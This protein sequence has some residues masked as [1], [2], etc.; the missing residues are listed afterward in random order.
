MNAGLSLDEFYSATDTLIGA[1][2]SL[3]ASSKIAASFSTLLQATHARTE[4]R[5]KVLAATA[6]PKYIAL[7][8]GI[9]DDAL[10][11]HLDLCEDDNASVRH[12]AIK[13]LPAFAVSVPGFTSKV[14]DV[15]CQ[16]LQTDNTEEAAV[17]SASLTSCFYSDPAASST[18]IFHQIS[19]N[20][21]PS[22]RRKS[23]AFLQHNFSASLSPSAALAYI[24]GLNQFLHAASAVV[25][26]GQSPWI[27]E[28]GLSEMMA[29]ICAIVTSADSWYSTDP[30]I[31]LTA[32]EMVSS[33][34]ES[35]AL[36]DPAS[37]SSIKTLTTAVHQIST[38]CLK[39]PALNSSA[40]MDFLFA[41]VFAGKQLRKFSSDTNRLYALRICADAAKFW[42]PP[43][44]LANNSG[45]VL[46][47]SFKVLSAGIEDL[48]KRHIPSSEDGNLSTLMYSKLE[49]ILVILY[50]VDSKSP[51]ELQKYTAHKQ[52]DLLLHLRAIYKSA[53][54]AI[55]S[56]APTSAV[57][58]T[59]PKLQKQRK[60]LENVLTVVK[61]LL[62]SRRLRMPF[63]KF[64][65]TF[66]ASWRQTPTS[67]FSSSI[68]SP[69]AATPDQ[70]GKTAE[71]GASVSRAGSASLIKSQ[72]RG[73]TVSIEMKRPVSA[74]IRSID[75]QPSVMF[76][77]H[78]VV[79][80][81]ESSSRIK[82]K[83]I[84]WNG[85]EKSPVPVQVIDV[86]DKSNMEISSATSHSPNSI[87]TSKRKHIHEN[88]SGGPSSPNKKQQVTL[89]S[90]SVISET[91]IPEHLISGIHSVTAHTTAL[92]NSESCVAANSVSA[93]RVPQ[94]KPRMNTRLSRTYIPEEFEGSQIS[95]PQ[96]KPLS[97]VN[98]RMHELDASPPP[99]YASHCVPSETVKIEAPEVTL[100]R[101]SIVGRAA[102]SDDTTRN[103]RNM[104]SDADQFA[105]P[106][107][108]PEI[109][110]DLNR[111]VLRAQPKD[112]YQFCAN[113]FH[114]KLA[115]QRKELIELASAAG[116]DSAEKEDSDTA[117]ND[118]K[119]EEAPS[120]P[121]KDSDDED[122]DDD[123]SEEDDQPAMPPPPPQN[124]NRGRR[125]SVSAESMAPTLDKD[126]VAVV[127]PKSDE[128]KSRIQAS[129]KNNF[130][131]RSCDEEQYRD[132]VDA[133]AE[134]RVK[135]GEEVIRQG[136]V[137]DYFYVVETGFLDV[138]VSKNGSPPAK[139]YEY[140]DGGSFGELALMYNAPRAATVTATAD[141]IL[142]A[143]DRVTFRRILMENTSRKRRMYEGF[144]EEVK[145]LASLEP[146]ERHK[147]ADVLESQVFNDGDI[148]IKQGDVGEQ[149]YI[150]E[151]G[152][153]SVTKLIDGVE[154][155]YPGLKKGD[156]F[157]ELALLTDQPRQ[158]TIRA[159]GRLKV[160]TMGKKAFVRLLGPVVDIIKRNANDYAQIKSHINN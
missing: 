112:I 2:E 106:A 82:F 73:I 119:A 6:I 14:V 9:A 20:S 31:A 38:I 122:S 142:W 54:I 120:A 24:Q 8:P 41:R 74:P 160:A 94:K 22:I 117:Q 58:E 90:S 124:H 131:F 141:S 125:T 52:K 65:A 152:D 15:L 130:L 46:H 144:L 86:T 75:I 87:S 103:Q 143:L 64:T 77:S 53:Q 62:K 51:E 61:E 50:Y 19:L 111:E 35:V 134:K 71:K 155:Q 97:S 78:E 93:A 153:A 17:V 10:D 96:S 34:I 36:F 80:L 101:I 136:G 84:V 79:S 89:K 154:H 42:G 57:C 25:A 139:V 114:G 104:S 85:G 157:G 107:E 137:G 7:V 138:F 43:V 72:S 70:G 32:L 145:L 108:F 147:I 30:K 121:A 68:V 59:V 55:G 149:F 88:E 91:T 133:M 45:G 113:Y 26:A 146:Y 4:T 148:V 37:G 48:I 127:I 60:A 92:T 81:E 29:S 3:T 49:C 115:D 13:A 118:Q 126:F 47:P 129:I 12:A 83:Q 132:V 5:V 28:I 105:V 18:A 44:V 56:L 158:A 98:V 135:A 11:S 69:S 150:I 95:A 40:F 23:L 140:T 21:V 33:S 63:S 128:Q 1:R 67:S 110:K 102:L 100:R 159:I 39:Y 151:S 76:N 66:R 123:E 27:D 109:L 156:Y 116:D 16:L 99:S